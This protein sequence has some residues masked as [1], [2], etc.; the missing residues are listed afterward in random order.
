MG[1]EQERQGRKKDKRKRL[2]VGGDRLFPAVI[3][4]NSLTR[5]RIL[6]FMCC[7]GCLILFFFLFNNRF[8]SVAPAPPWRRLSVSQFVSPL[9][10]L[11]R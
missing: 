5:V 2:S 4:D 3:P 10:F 7:P 6:Y 9:L 11:G 8:V 1:R